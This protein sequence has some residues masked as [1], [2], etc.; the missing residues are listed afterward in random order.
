MSETARARRGGEG[1]ARARRGGEGAASAWIALRRVV[2]W[3]HL[4]AGAGAGAVVL[5][6][7]ATGVVLALE[8]TVAGLALDRHRVDVG[9]GLDDGAGLDFDAGADVGAG[10]DDGARSGG[11][12]DEGRV[13]QGRLTVAELIEAAMAAPGAGAAVTSLRYRA[14]PGAP[15]RAEWGRDRYAEMHPFTGEVLAVGPGRRE[16]F[17]EA[18]HDWHRWLNVSDASVRRGRAVTGAANVAFLFL[19][20]TGPLLWLPWPPSRRALGRALRPGARVLRAAPALTVHQLTGIGSVGL[21]GVLAVTAM[22]TSYPAAGDRMAGL[23]GR[24]VP[25]GPSGEALRALP[26]EGGGAEPAAG[27]DPALTGGGVAADEADASG[28]AAV[29]GGGAGPDRALRAAQA[30]V[31]G[32]RTVVLA[33]PRPRPGGE[34]GGGGAGSGAIGAPVEVEVQQGRA[35]QPHR[36][37]RLVVAA[38]TGAVLEWES[39]ADASPGRRGQEF[40]RY[41]HTGEYW[42]PAGRAVA[43]AA[44]LGAA[45]VAWTGLWLA[46]KRARRWFG[47]RG[48]ARRARQRLD[49]KQ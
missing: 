10:G 45:V 36:T 33:V 44:A 35:G 14:D 27:G 32:W 21:M 26:V 30:A 37:H 8:E 39:F 17:F 48:G 15:V 1:G 5:V 28:G 2:F 43:G 20:L 38:A 7:A 41:A 12:D 4:T 24:V 9:A 42:G 13:G 23:A 22:A 11:T 29:L 3:L 46:L 6:M 19:L 49:A 18:M 16:A 31:P 47:R 25:A 40:L 34:A